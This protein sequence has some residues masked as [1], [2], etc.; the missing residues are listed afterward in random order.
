MGAPSTTS[1]RVKGHARAKRSHARPRTMPLPHPARHRHDD[2]ARRLRRRDRPAL[3]DAARTSRAVDGEGRVRLIALHRAHESREAARP[4]ARAR[5]AHDAKP[6]HRE[7][8]RLHRA[9][10][11]EAHEH[12]GAPAPPPR[13]ER[14][15]RP[16]PEGEDPRPSATRSSAGSARRARAASRATRA[17]RT[18]RS[19]PSERARTAQPLSSESFARALSSAGSFSMARS[20]IWTALALSPCF[21]LISPR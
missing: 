16:V 21:A 4:A 18:P 1:T 8:T 11:R 7:R 14:P 6:L 5:A 13:E 12:D 17:R 9:V 20:N 19:Q 2:G 10:A 3:D 15:L